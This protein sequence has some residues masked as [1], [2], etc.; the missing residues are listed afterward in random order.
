MNG[1]FLKYDG[2]DFIL[3]V[4]RE[5]KQAFEYIEFKIFLLLYFE[6]V[7]FTRVLNSNTMMAHP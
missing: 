4:C 2:S 3:W 1:R 6:A 7:F 5:Q